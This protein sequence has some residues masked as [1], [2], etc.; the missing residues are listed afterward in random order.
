MNILY[1][2]RTQGMGAEGSHIAGMVEAFRKLGHAVEVLGPPG[3]ADPSNPAARTDPAAGPASAEA[4][5]PDALL[6]PLRS[7]YRFLAEKSPQALFEA[8]EV[9]YNLPL[10]LRLLPRFAWARP[11]LVY[12]RYALNTV[13]PSFLCRLF[14]VPHLLEVNDATVIERSRAL[15]FRR[16]GEKAEGFCLRSASLVITITEDFKKRLLGRFGLQADLVLV[17]TNA[18]SPARFDAALARNE[19]RPEAGREAGIPKRPS[20]APLIIGMSG[21]FLAWHGIVE[22]LRGLGP[23]A[24]A[25]NLSFLFVGDGPVRGE[26]EAEARGL[27]IGARLRFTGML[28]LSEVPDRLAAFDIAVI[29]RAASHASP[30]KLMEYM[31]MGLPIVAPDMPSIR[32]A[33]PGEGLALF[34]PAGD[35][36]AMRERVLELVADPARG[37]ELGRAARAH[38][39]AHL[40]WEGHARQVLQ[41]LRRS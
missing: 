3:A 37:R 2:H 33:L 29:P 14:G 6:S 26:A 39:L 41:A 9:L 7:M 15:R 22:L 35:M 21:Q 17:L 23:L 19:A 10:F 8:A 16:L 20:G 1:V 12:E 36:D 30:M 5:R 24:E 28:P 38:L 4:R 32:A 40:T 25:H 11:A 18:V 27:G 34:F 31:A 13:A